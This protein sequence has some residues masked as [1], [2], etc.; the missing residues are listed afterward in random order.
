MLVGDVR[1]NTV[2]TTIKIR[3]KKVWCVINIKKRCRRNDEDLP[4]KRVG[5]TRYSDAGSKFNGRGTG[6]KVV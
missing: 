1:Y 2:R 4:N 5:W 6:Q 3:G